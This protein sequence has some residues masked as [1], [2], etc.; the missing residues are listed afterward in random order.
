MTG[1]IGALS[2]CV[3]M[4]ALSCGAFGFI[5]IKYLCTLFSIIFSLFLKCKMN[6]LLVFVS[7]VFVYLFYIVLL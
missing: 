2:L 6:L 7:G 5:F 3:F 1:L 4:Y